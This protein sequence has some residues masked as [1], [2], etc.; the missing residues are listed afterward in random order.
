MP[1]ATAPV[2]VEAARADGSKSTRARGGQHGRED[3]VARLLTLES[4]ASAADPCPQIPESFVDP[5]RIVKLA[6]ELKPVPGGAAAVA[7]APD[8]EPAAPAALPESAT[9]TP[10][11]VVERRVA[12]SR[13][14]WW[15]FGPHVAQAA[16]RLGLLEAP[17]KAFVGDGAENNWTLPQRF[18]G[19]VVAILDFIHALSYVLAAALAGRPFAAG[20]PIHVR[21]IGWVWEGHV[22][23]MIAE[24]AQRQAELGTPAKGESET[25][26]RSMVSQ[27]LTYLQNHKDKMRYDTYRCAGLPITSSLMESLR[28]QINQRVKGTEKFWIEEGAEA[29]LQRRADVLSDDQ[30]LAAFWQRRQDRQTGQRPYQ[31]AA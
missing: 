14:N 4:T 2:G 24:L 28:K 9:Y 11:A 7:D 10:P 31:M 26:P 8:G 22:E 20:W 5:T 23:R 25:S 19:S 12:A 15:D 29:V 30:P 13:E 17:R 16:R 21:W 3:R 27:A 1:A 6:R 18:F